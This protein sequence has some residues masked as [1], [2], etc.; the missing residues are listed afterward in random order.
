[1]ARPAAASLLRVRANR[2]VKP[3][4]SR[5]I[6][7]HRWSDLVDFAKGSYS[8]PYSSGILSAENVDEGLCQMLVIGHDPSLQSNLSTTL[9]LLADVSV[10]F[11]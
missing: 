10:H 8:G 2:F 4:H 11:G 5:P 1:M 3:W 7:V 9:M 6:D